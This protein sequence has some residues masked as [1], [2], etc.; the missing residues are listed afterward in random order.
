[1]SAPDQALPA[2]SGRRSFAGV[3]FAPHHAAV[4]AVLALAAVLNLNALSQN[5]FANTYYSA[6]VKSMLGSWHNFVFVAFDPGGLVSVDKPPLALWLQAASAK[7]FGFSS[8]SLLVPEAICGVLAVGALYVI[9]SRRFGVWAGVAAALALAVFPSLVAVARD[10]GPDA[11]LILL[12]VLAAGAALTAIET[13]RL[14]TL[15]L[16]ALLVGLAFNTKMLAAFLVVPG[17]L[18]AYLVCAPGPFR[19]R[20]GHVLA[21]GVLLAVVSVAWLSVVAL[22][23]AADRPWVGSSSDNS[24]FSL[25]LG[26]NGLGR[27]EGQLGGPNQLGGA[28]GGAAGGGPPSFRGGVQPPFAGG[29]PGGAPTGGASGAGGQNGAS[30]GGPPGGGGP[31]GGPPSGGAGGGG[32]GNVFGGPTGP[33]RLVGDALGGQGGWMLGFGL[34]GALAIG[35]TL[36]RS[37][38]DPRL[39]ALI[40]FGAWFA[41]EALILSFSEGIVHPYYVSALG[42][43]LAVLVGAGAV[44]LA[45]LAKRGGWRLVLPIAAVA[46]TVVVQLVLLGRDDYLGWWSPLLV[47]GSAGALA[48][49]AFWRKLAGPMVALLL[50]LLLVAPAA[51]ASTVWDAPVNGTFPAAGP[52]QGGGLGLGGRPVRQLRARA[53]RDDPPSRDPLGPADRELDERVS[54]DPQRSQRRLDRRLQRRR[55]GTDR[56][57]GGAL[58]GDRRGEVLPAGRHVPRPDREPGRDGGGEGVSGDHGGGRRF[59]RLRPGWRERHDL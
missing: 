57:A 40:V 25:A 31:G 33:L 36:R 14:R 26:Y 44:A 21:A 19:R 22:T 18:V 4:A 29:I 42:P 15:L 35:L 7:L 45:S 27:V 41:V 6:A 51:Y 23:P 16:C 8:L 17:I 12:M 54:V 53:L 59:V 39:A 3:R 32:P 58:R 50:G 34:V 38:R 30:T 37:R 28:G 13:G 5:G 48:V 52:S 9:V 55:P 43:G 1:M 20:V 24:A 11:L 56:G 2:G 46:I 47:V 49:M 10:N